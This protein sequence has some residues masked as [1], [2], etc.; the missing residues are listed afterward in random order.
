[1]TSPG[2][3]AADDYGRKRLFYG[4][5]GVGIYVIVDLQQE[6]VVLHTGPHERGYQRVIT[7]PFGTPLELPEPVGL[8][9]DTAA[10]GKEA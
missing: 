2:N 3:T 4:R 6:E 10:F 9:L 5:A 7:V 8:T 1:M